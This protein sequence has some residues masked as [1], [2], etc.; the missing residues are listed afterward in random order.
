MKSKMSWVGKKSAEW[1]MEKEEHLLKG[2]NIT[3]VLGTFTPVHFQ[4]APN[5]S[6][7]HVQ[8]LPSQGNAGGGKM[9]WVVSLQRNKDREKSK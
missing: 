2:I 1:G 6:F 7:G 4:A 8:H 5:T 9:P 3:V